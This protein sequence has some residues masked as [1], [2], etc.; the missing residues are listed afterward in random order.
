MSQLFWKN[1]LVF[2]IY[3]VAVG[4][5]SGSQKN[6]VSVGITFTINTVTHITIPTMR[7][8]GY[9]MAPL[10]FRVMESTFSV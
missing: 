5:V 9:V 4:S 3:C 6:E 2:R 8:I 10:I 1:A 7:S